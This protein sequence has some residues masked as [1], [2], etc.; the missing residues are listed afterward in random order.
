MACSPIIAWQI[1]GGK[2]ESSDRFPLHGLQNHWGRWLQPWNQKTIA[3]WQ[4]SDDKPRQCVE[5]QRHYSANRSPFSQGYG[6]PSGHIWLW[7]Q[8]HKEGRMLKNWCL[9]TVVL[10]KILRIPWTARRSNK[11]ILR[12][13]TLNTHWK[14][15]C[16]SWNSSILVVW[17]EQLTHWK[18]PWWW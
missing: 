8:D 17:C 1:E 6:L 5:K 13:S 2:G 11:S 7:E 4:E 12:E 3:S 18:N 15:W 9:Q 10:E 14:D 16:W